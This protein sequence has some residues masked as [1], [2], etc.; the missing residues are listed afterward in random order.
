[1]VTALTGELA[2]VRERLDTTERLLEA[3]GVL[4]RA[5]IEG[6][7]PTPEQAEERSLIRRRLIAKTFRPLRDA[8]ERDAAGET[9]L[10]GSH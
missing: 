4:Q 2:V 1:M 10:A 6:F 3:E 9:K 8:A 7:D 5:A